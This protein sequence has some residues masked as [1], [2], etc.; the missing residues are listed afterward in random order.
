MLVSYCAKV[1]YHIFSLFILSSF[2]LESDRH[3][4]GSFLFLS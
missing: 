1:D 4:S 3:K 2:V